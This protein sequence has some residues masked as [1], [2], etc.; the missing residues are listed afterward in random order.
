[1]DDGATVIDDRLLHKV[2]SLLA[3]AESTPYPEEADALTAKAQALMDRH[4]IDAAVLAASGRG[5]AATASGRLVVIDDPYAR[6]KY[7]L[8]S[9]VARANRS[10]AV[11]D[12]HHRR[13]TVVGFPVDLEAVEL[14]FTSLLIQAT[15]AMLR[16]GV[17]GDTRSRAYRHAFLVSYAGRIG[18]RLREAAAAVVA[19][20][21]A[22]HGA[23][24]LPVLAGRELA[25]DDELARQFP[26]LR[27]LRVSVSHGGGWGAGRAAA[28]RAQLHRPASTLLGQ[29][30]R[31]LGVE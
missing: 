28:D 17:D 3:K 24:V 2:R 10:R 7:L 26:R 27:N 1:M 21:T 13:A 4:S 12:P 19:E 31:S 25:V 22:A 30:S 15:A 16:A 18:Q 9:E 29:R 14:L 8:L 20:A 6:A 5:P 11:F 23:S